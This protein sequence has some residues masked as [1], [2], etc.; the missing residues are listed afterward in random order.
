MCNLLVDSH[1]FGT[2]S[3][4]FICGTQDIH[5]QLEQKIADFHHMEDTI[6]YPSCFDANAVNNPMIILTQ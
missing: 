2:A 6:L 1:G 3:V 5:K 4:R